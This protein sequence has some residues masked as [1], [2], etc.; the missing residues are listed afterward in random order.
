[1]TRR[2]TECSQYLFIPPFFFPSH[3]PFLGHCLTLLHNQNI[4]LLLLL[5]T[6]IVYTDNNFSNLPYKLI[7]K[8]ISFVALRNNLGLT[9]NSKSHLLNL[10]YS[11]SL[12]FVFI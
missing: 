2:L 7:L 10:Q 6:S 9:F 1:M 11:L 8:A 5:P 3:L 4:V 12:A